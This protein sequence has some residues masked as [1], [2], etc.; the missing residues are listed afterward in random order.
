MPH[1]CAYYKIWEPNHGARSQ[2][3]QAVIF[4][5]DNIKADT[6]LGANE[7]VGNLLEL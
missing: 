6:W 3:R 4:D 1:Y 2:E 5:A 7:E